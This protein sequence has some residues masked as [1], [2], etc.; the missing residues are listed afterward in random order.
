MTN[1]WVKTAQS[2][3]EIELLIKSQLER[4]TETH[5]T[6][7]QAYVLQSLDIKD[8]QQPSKLARYCGREATS[9]TPIL[10]G[11]ERAKLIYRKPDPKDRR[12]VTIHLTAR[13]KS[14]AV[15]V[16]QALAEVETEYQS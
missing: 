2:L 16:A 13:G 7:V 9:F 6:V 15:V 14:L 3:N 10:D 12:A 5:L 8:G 1:L 11:M 4:L